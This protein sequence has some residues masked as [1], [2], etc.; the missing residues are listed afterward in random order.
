[1]CS[2]CTGNVS[3][4]SLLVQDPMAHVLHGVYVCAPSLEG[5]VNEIV[6]RLAGKS[7]PGHLAL[8]SYIAFWRQEMR[9]QYGVS[10]LVYPL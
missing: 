3:R 7:N 6:P 2:P 10:S 9:Q 5:V 1:M 4:F 8:V